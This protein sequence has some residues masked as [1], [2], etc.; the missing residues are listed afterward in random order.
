M[1]LYFNDKVLFLAN[2]QWECCMKNASYT[3][4]HGKTVLEFIEKADIVL[5]KKG[6][7]NYKCI[8]NNLEVK[9]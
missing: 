9:R 5:V 4:G 3:L 2:Y 6:K 8:K 7:N 1:K